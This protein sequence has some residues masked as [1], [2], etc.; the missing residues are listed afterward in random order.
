MVSG[1]EPSGQ[2]GRCGPGVFQKQQ[3]GGQYDWN[4]VSGEGRGC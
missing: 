1:E 4:G 2:E 3:A